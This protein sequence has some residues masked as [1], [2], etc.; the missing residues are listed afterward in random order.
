[1]GEGPGLRLMSPE[2]KRRSEKRKV[3]FLGEVS[4]SFARLVL[5]K[6]EIGMEL[7]AGETDGDGKG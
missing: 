7:R 3:V 5:E 1:M 2:R 4:E 6:K